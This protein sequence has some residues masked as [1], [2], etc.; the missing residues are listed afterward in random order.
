MSIP[1]WICP[2]LMANSGSLG[3]RIQRPLLLRFISFWFEDLSGEQSS[4]KGMTNTK[5]LT[6]NVHFLNYYKSI[7]FLRFE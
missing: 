1:H 6:I 2:P 3:I 4:E 5:S 7:I